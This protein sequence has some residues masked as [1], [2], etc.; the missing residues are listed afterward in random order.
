MTQTNV[1]RRALLGSSAAAA[2]ALSAPR[3]RARPADG[4]AYEIQRSDAEWREMLTADEYLI[5]RDGQ[6]EWPKTSA[7]WEETAEGTYHCKGC[8]LPLFESN[9]KVVLDKGWVFFEHSIDNA[10]LTGID[11][12]VRQY[13][14]N[15]MA[16]GAIAMIEIH[17]RQCGCHIGHFLEVEG[18]N[19]HCMNGTALDFRAV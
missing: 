9:W 19:L 12:P 3:A 18:Q 16:V 15:E 11:G 5:L 10:V 2:A 17:C 13:G 1:T 8:A 7:L 4:F 14:Q 6:T